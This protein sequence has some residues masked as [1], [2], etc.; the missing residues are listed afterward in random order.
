MLGEGGSSSVDAY[1]S[2]S[3]GSDMDLLPRRRSLARDGA[4]RKRLQP[5]EPVVPR[6]GVGSRRL[7][8]REAVDQLL[9]EDADLEA[10]EVRAEA[11]VDALPEGEVGV[12][13]AQEVEAEGLAEDALVAVGGHLPRGHLVAGRELLAAELDLVRDRAPLVD[14]G[15]R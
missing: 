2:W 12:R 4:H 14:R 11:V 6:P 1:G 5:E 15:R 3:G 9:E 13:V 7:E 10:R 8:G